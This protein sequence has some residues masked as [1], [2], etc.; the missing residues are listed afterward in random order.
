MLRVT[1]SLTIIA[2]VACSSSALAQPG[3]KIDE[4]LS[5]FEEVP[6]LSTPGGGTFRARI[7]KDG[8]AIA[9][10]LSY[11]NLESDVIMAHLHFENE[12]NNGPIV[13]WLCDNTGNGPAGIQDCPEQPATIDGTIVAADVSSTGASAA[14]IAAGLGA[15]EL[16]ELI[17]AI[18]AG[19]IYVN[20]HS[21]SRPGGEIRSQL[22]HHHGHGPK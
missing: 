3:K 14:A 2:L 11:R 18:R 7:A 16:D 19:A 15:G 10:E 12:T 17:D 21:E 4:S 8:S 22:E 9:W 20:V 6:A 1:L 13:V 5:S